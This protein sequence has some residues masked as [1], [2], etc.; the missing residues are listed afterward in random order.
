METLKM[1]TN[2][3]YKLFTKYF[4]TIRLF[5]QKYQVGTMYE[6]DF[7]GK[8]IEVECVHITPIRLADIPEYTF[9]TDTGYDKETSLKIVKEM[10]K[11]T[12]IDVN[13]VPFAII[14]FKQNL[15]Y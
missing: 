13:A 5:S 11:N 6:L 12:K 15:N 1:S 3:N 14:V 4:T 7:K 8:K 2:W 10:Y 9:F